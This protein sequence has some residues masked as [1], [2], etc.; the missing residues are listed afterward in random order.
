MY[1]IYKSNLTVQIHLHYSTV[2]FVYTNTSTLTGHRC[3][4]R[5]FLTH[6]NVGYPF[7][8]VKQKSNTRLSGIDIYPWG[9]VSFSTNYLPYL[10][11]LA[12]QQEGTEQYFSVGYCS[13]PWKKSLSIRCQWNPNEW[14]FK[15]KSLG[16][17]FLKYCLLCLVGVDRV[18]LSSSWYCLLCCQDGLNF[19]VFEWNP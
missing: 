7:I 19:W 4:I 13:F 16:R 5:F 8:A 11:G 17:N 6:L 14:P 12:I 2:V 9:E 10:I 1:C 3:S 18:V 15:W